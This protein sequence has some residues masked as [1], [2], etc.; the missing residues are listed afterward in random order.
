MIPSEFYTGFLGTFW[1]LKRTDYDAINF[2]EKNT[3]ICIWQ[4]TNEM[5]FRSQCEGWDT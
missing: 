3:Q 5:V 1:N 4:N 2:V